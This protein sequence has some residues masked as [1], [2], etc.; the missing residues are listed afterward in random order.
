LQAALSKKFKVQGIPT[1]VFVNAATGDLITKNGRNIVG[2]DPQGKNFPWTPEPFDKII[3]GQFTNKDGA[4]I[5]WEDCKDKTVGLYFSAHWCPPCRGFTPQLAT[6]YNEMKTANKNLEII[7]VSSD[8]SDE[9]YKEYLD[10]MPWY[11]I[12]YDDKRKDKLDKLFE[13]SGIPS[14][15]ILEGAT[16]K[17]ITENGRSMVSADPKGEDFPWHPKALEALHGGKV[18]DVN[19]RVCMI[20]FTDGS[21]DQITQAKTAMDPVATPY[22]EANKDNDDAVVFMYA[23]NDSLA[24]RLQQFVQISPPFPILALVNMT[25]QVKYICDDSNLTEDTVRK[26][27]EDYQQEKLTSKTFK[28]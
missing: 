25:D 8:N 28:E 13:I 18:D 6:F 14:L 17:V 7:F 24:E 3:N 16:G 22:F 4:S 21:D 19:E 9:E 5:T 27:L 11:A 2:D 26:F 20:W 1:L 10:E 12:P 23:K 15:I